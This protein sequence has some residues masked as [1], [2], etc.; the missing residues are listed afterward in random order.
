MCIGECKVLYPIHL[1]VVNSCLFCVRACMYI[2]FQ[3]LL[4][5]ISF[6]T[7]MLS[8][9]RVRVW[10]SFIAMHMLKAEKNFTF[11]VRR[12][13]QTKNHRHQCQQNTA[14]DIIQCSSWIHNNISVCMCVA[15]WLFEKNPCWWKKSVFTLSCILAIRNIQIKEW[16]EKEETVRK[17]LSIKSVAETK[18]SKKKIFEREKKH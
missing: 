8:T 11:Y 5:C 2:K 17:E 1:F 7:Q 9:W 18:I 13:T 4:E 16:S 3:K 6:L 15:H 14:C 12:H 10:N